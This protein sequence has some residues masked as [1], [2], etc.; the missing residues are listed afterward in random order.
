[1]LD[2]QVIAKSMKD[3]HKQTVVDSRLLSYM[4]KTSLEATRRDTQTV[5]NFSAGSEILVCWQCAAKTLQRRDD[6]I[7]LWDALFKTALQ[8]DIWDDVRFVGVCS[9]PSIW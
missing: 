4:Y 9:F 7:A 1:M 6:R 2:P 8:E 5:V 3:V